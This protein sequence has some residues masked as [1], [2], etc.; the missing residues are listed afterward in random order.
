[1]AL[2]SLAATL[3]GGTTT[4]AEAAFPGMNGLIAYATTD[5]SINSDEDTIFEAP[6]GTG[7]AGSRVVARW[8]ETRVLEHPA[9]RGQ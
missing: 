3:T 5:G 8:N 7:L 1:V 6:E 2:L 4:P 9:L